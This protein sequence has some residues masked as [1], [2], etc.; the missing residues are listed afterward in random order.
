MKSRIKKS[1]EKK[2][3]SAACAHTPR[4]APAARTTAVV[5][6]AAAFFRVAGDPARLRLLEQL[7]GGEYCVSDLATHSGE[8]LSTVSERLRLLRAAGLVNRRRH[9]KHVYYALAD[10]HVAELIRSALDHAT[11]DGQEAQKGRSR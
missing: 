2:E 5:A 9:G 3:G 10:A 4:P 6:R 11:E 7:A 1:A 8:Q